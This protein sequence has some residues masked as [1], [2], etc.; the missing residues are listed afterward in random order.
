VSPE[1]PA[2]DAAELEA[3][4]DVLDSTE[5]GDKVI[6]GGAARTGAY[7]GGILLGLLSTPLM[8]RH[9]GVDDFG[10]F[11]T[12][13]SLM[14]IVT[15][16]TEGGLSAIGVR[17]Y[18]VRD[19]AGRARLVSD[20]LGL[21]IVLAVVAVL[22]ALAFALLAG[23]PEVMVWGIAI[24]AVGLWFT[25]WFHVYA[26]PMTAQLRLGWLA[27]LELLRQG[28]TSVAIVVL[29]VAGATLLPFFA[30]IPLAS[31]VALIAIWLLVHRDV[32]GR[33]TFHR[34]RWWDLLRDS[35][36]Y[37][38]AL[39][40]SVLY[41]RVGVIVTSIVSGETE[42]GYYS[43]A[44]RIVELVSGVPWLLVASAFPV[45][46][47]A[48]R[49]DEQRLR[50]ALGRTFEVTL[51]LGVAVAIAI[52]LGAPVAVEIVGGNEFE[53]SVDVLAVLGAAMVGTFLIACWGHAL[54]TLRRHAALLVAN[55]SAFVLGTGLAIVLVSAHGALGAAIATTATELWLAA[56]YLVL[57]VRARPDL[58]PPAAIVPAVAL[59]AAVAVAPPLLIGLP[60]LASTLLAS[61]LFFAV[62]ALLGRI[63]PEIGQALRMSRSRGA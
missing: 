32:P 25:N 30:A 50:Y 39:A 63:P 4:A 41:F 7:V 3:Q 16:L 19:S 9:L 61:A 15:G 48:A 58:R 6:R 18:S 13:G 57:L 44:F 22:T 42:T 28:L 45:L 2:D 17:E 12:V 5:A 10:A 26:V 46:S 54:L 59:A 53:P 37:A 8:V 60:S 35:L 52:A 55:L 27:A 62:L 43:L 56:V 11:V 49:D 47:R 34:A 1:W 51:I 33:P 14:F 24:S 40:V 31:I 36:P 29:V 38:A 20:L 21:R 23:Y